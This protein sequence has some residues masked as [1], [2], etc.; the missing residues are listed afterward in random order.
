[1]L[2]YTS[3]PNEVKSV[4]RGTHRKRERRRNAIDSHCAGLLSHDHVNSAPPGRT[5]GSHRRRSTKYKRRAQELLSRIQI[6]DP[7]YSA[8]PLLLNRSFHRGDPPIMETNVPKSL[9]FP[10]LLYQTSG[11]QVSPG[12]HS[13]GR[14]GWWLALRLFSRRVLSDCYPN[15]RRAGDIPCPIPWI[16]TR[17]KI[18]PCCPRRLST[19]AFAFTRFRFHLFV[20]PP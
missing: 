17:H 10:C 7:A 1:M 16:I 20:S 11:Y 18:P 13:R 5:A 12:C 4:E 6:M 8:A 19:S 3:R 14:G 15:R 2:R 9:H